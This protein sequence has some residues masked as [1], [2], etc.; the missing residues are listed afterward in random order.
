MQGGETMGDDLRQ[1]LDRELIKETKARYFRYMDTK[2]WDKWRTCFTDDCRFEMSKD[3][4]DPDEWVRY[5]AGN[6]HGAR[7]AHHGHMPEITF[8]GTDTAR[9]IWAMYDIV[10]FS[11]AADGF[12]RFGHYE[13]DEGRGFVGFGYYEEEYRRVGDEWKISFMRLTRLR[14]DALLGEPGRSMEIPNDRRPSLDWLP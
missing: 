13:A 12:A 3:I 14:V 4:D 2:Q 10:E 1:L 9:V 6:V 11:E 7:T 8:T 5:V